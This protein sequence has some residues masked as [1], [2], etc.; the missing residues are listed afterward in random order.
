MNV[1]PQ[2][3]V[4]FV[5]MPS[6]VVVSISFCLLTAHSHL[7][8]TSGLHLVFT[9]SKTAVK[10]HTDEEFVY[11]HLILTYSYL[12]SMSINLILNLQCFVF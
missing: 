8:R 11:F 10:Q 2:G 6:E 5:S 4:C 7:R 1:D 12:F 9:A 3:R